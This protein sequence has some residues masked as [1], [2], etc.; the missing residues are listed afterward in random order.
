LFK[1]R[2][3]IKKFL[4]IGLLSIFVLYIIL[5]IPGN[6]QT[7][8]KG[9]DQLPFAWKQDN[10]WEDLEKRFIES[11]KQGCDTLAAEI[12]SGLTVGNYLIDSISAIPVNP[13]AT[14][15][16]RLENNTFEL[17][18][19][20]AACPKYLAKF[21]SYVIKLRNTV[22]DQSMHWDMNSNAAQESIYRLLYGARGA[23]EEIM[24][25][26]PSDSLPALMLCNDEPSATASTKIL[27][28]TIHS[29]DILVSRGGAPTSALI[30]RGNNFQGNF[31]H[32][33]LVYV[34]P[35]T[36]LASIIESHIEKGVA[37]ASLE[38]YLKDKKLRVMVLRLRHNCPALIKWP[39]WRYRK[40]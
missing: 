7:I 11:K 32:V 36:N 2:I 33:A 21:Q 23:L 30:A 5:L 4:L 14:V 38:N 26:Q 9:S 34:D 17:A 19:S 10:R 22:K 13:E 6:E 31:S 1:K 15:L 8:T 3:S 40:P 12:E 29:G 24:L 37:V 20:I 25:Q 39:R 18:V 35:K 27:G 28:A 16:N